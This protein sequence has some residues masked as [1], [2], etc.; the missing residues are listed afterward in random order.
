MEAEVA[1]P[2][3]PPPGTRAKRARG[4][5]GTLRKRLGDWV[6]TSGRWS[7]ILTSAL[8]GT[9]S[10]LIAFTAF[11][12]SQYSDFANQ[13]DSLANRQ[14]VDSLNQSQ[15]DYAEHLQDVE[16]WLQIVASGDDPATSPLTSLLSAR[17]LEAVDR[18]EAL[19]SGDL[20]AELPIDDRY[21][22]E[23]TIESLAFEQAID[24]SYDQ[25]REAGSYSARLTGASVIYSAALLLLTLASSTA[26]HSAK[27][28]L[29]GAAL[30]IIV[31]AVLI[32]AAP[33]RWFS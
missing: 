5:R 29:N 27:L 26:R 25:A 2:T 16:I 10:L 17:W 33:V 19:K 20:T 8:L 28:A 3:A 22:E 24:E 6:N 9:V 15:A 11:Q 7:R 14:S 23:L 18:A 12:A 31:V 4:E 21:F 32:G 1:P 13:M 30:F